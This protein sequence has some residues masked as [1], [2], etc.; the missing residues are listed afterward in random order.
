M[1]ATRIGRAFGGL[2]QHTFVKIAR[3][4]TVDLREKY[5]DTATVIGGRIYRHGNVT[6]V[7]WSGNVVETWTAPDEKQARR[8]YD[9]MVVRYNEAT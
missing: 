5:D 7:W 4:P 1:S 2:P 8:E 9:D 3:T 6:Q